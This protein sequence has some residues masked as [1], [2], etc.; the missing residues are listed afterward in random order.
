MNY[1]YVE[2]KVQ[3][4]VEGKWE[5]VFTAESVEEATG[6]MF[7]FAKVNPTTVFQTKRVN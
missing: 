7:A 5:T 3:A 2:M 6:Q 4:K 1:Q